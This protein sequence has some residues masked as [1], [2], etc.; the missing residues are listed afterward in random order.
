MF[1][2]SG[3]F[4]KNKLSHAILVAVASSS[5][6]VTVVAQESGSVVEEVYVS[7]IRASLE[8]AMDIK[9]EAGGVVEAISAEDIGKFPDANLAESLQRISG[10]S[11]DRNAG[12]GN[13]VSVRGFGPNFNMV[14]TNGR[15]MPSSGAGRSFNFN[16][17]AAELVSGVEVQKTSSAVN[18]SGGIGST[19]NINTA[20]PLDIGAFRV[21]GSVKGVSDIDEGS[22]TPEV[23]GL[24][25]NTFADGTF[26]VLFAASHQQ[27]KYE[28]ERV[29]VDGW[30]VNPNFGN[31]LLNPETNKTPNT[32]MPQNYNISL[33]ESERTRT[34]ANLVFQYAPSDSLTVTA[35]YLYSELHNEHKSS[36]FG[37][38]FNSGG[39]QNVLINENGTAI[40]MFEEGTFDNI[41]NWNE[42]VSENNSFGINVE[43]EVTDKFSM[44]FDANFAKSEQ[45]P[46]GEFNQYQAIVGYRNQQRFRIMDGAELP[47]VQDIYNANPGRVQAPNCAPA[48]NTGW[49]DAGF[50]NCYAW[51]AANG[52]DPN[53]SMTGT[54]PDGQIATDLLRAHRNDI[55]S[56]NTEDELNQF[57][58]EGNW[59]ED[60]IVFRAG[61]MY[62]DQS[63][64][65]RLKYNAHEPANVVEDFAGMY[66]FPVIGADALTRRTTIGSGFLDQFSGRQG[67]PSEWV[68]FDPSDVFA[69]IW[70]AMGD[71]YSQIPTE[72]SPNSYLVEEETLA[73]YIQLDV[74]T[75]FFNMPVHIQSGVRLE[76]TD[77]T[78]T[79]S[80]QVLTGFEYADPTSLKAIYAAGG[81][82]Q[83]TEKQSYDV[84][85]PN[86][87]VRLNITDDLVGRFAAGRTITRPNIASLRSTRTLGITRPG[88]EL[89][90]NAG[91]PGLK[92]FSADNIDLGLE[93]YYSELSYVSVGYFEKFIND[94]IVG[95]VREGTINN[96]TDPSSNGGSFENPNT[97]TADVGVFKI[98]SDV[99]GPT[100]KVRGTE[101][102]IQHAIGETGFGVGANA[103]F[104]STN[105]EL[106]VEDVSQR[107]AITGLSDSANMMG[108]YE[109]GPFQARITYNWRDSFLQGF[110]QVQGGDAVIVEDYGQ[111]DFSMSYDITDNVTVLLEGINVTSEGYRSHGRY[112]EQLYEAIST[113]SRYAV[114]IRASF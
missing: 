102:A 112:K 40:D 43:W 64:N 75:E 106:D 39:V 81:M 65:N 114:G 88:G 90:A 30:V 56:G 25:S 13:S 34:N 22:V 100:A 69:Y 33:Q 111:W 53:G 57:K 80:E 17:L 96:V 21:A 51:A 78:S 70:P 99:N 103:T 94:F 15:Q 24:I 92:P 71:G 83:Y 63:K 113:G 16:D 62:T 87:A 108:Y 66:G 4:N 91:N 5:L 97:T 3:M 31:R 72:W 10:V 107:F 82:T 6:S 49:T 42:T 74:D 9:R 26:G 73:S 89:N 29:A 67:L 8:R 76:S 85:L 48:T 105:R 55:Q 38:W 61:L 36:Q 95:G 35:D 104:V 46:G 58:I 27:R 11:I 47:T 41:Q 19:I 93:W 59:S 86:L 110:S 54:G 45:N 12:E 32:F 68:Y 52:L 28:Q 60:N 50:A 77:I 84:L 7:G 23:S 79:G 2:S 14:T 37:V 101:I 18:P 1:R 98:S 44:T 109:N 20:R